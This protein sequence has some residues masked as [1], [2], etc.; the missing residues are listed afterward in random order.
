MSTLHV[1]PYATLNEESLDALREAAGGGA[2][3]C[4]RA[5]AGQHNA[6][7]LASPDP[8]VADHLGR[9]FGATLADRG[10]DLADA[11][12]AGTADGELEGVRGR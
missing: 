9:R 3:P 1:R 8:L 4:T 11:V 6:M 10:R 12:W 2:S 7:G 5:P